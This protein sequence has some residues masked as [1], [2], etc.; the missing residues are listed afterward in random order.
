MYSSERALIEDVKREVL[1]DLRQRR[2]FTPA[3]NHL[4]ESIKDSVKNEIWAQM[5]MEQ[6]NQLA[7]YHG[8]DQSLSDR[9]LEKMVHDRYRTIDSMKADLKKELLALQRM[10]TRRSRDPQVREIADVLVEESQRRGIPMEHLIAGL[11]RK[12]PM[13]TGMTNRLSGILNSGQ[14][15]GFLYGMG[16][17]VLCYLLW[18]AARNNMRSMAL[19]SIE[20][21]VSMVDQVKNFVSE[22]YQQSTPPDFLNFNQETPPQENQPPDGGNMGS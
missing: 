12:S 2:H 21:G 10:E 19:R 1:D 16:T 20:E 7:R 11:D 4:Y 13:G 5:E 14:R 3:E 9:R 8:L 15:T 17:A 6:A 22:Q 18:P